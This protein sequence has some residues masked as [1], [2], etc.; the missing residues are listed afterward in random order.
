MRNTI[1][2]IIA[3][4]L[5][6]ACSVFS[7][8]KNEP[9]NSYVLNTLP[10]IHPQKSRHQITVLVTQPTTSDI[11]N[12]TQMVY[13]IGQHQVAYFAK[14][15]WADTP[16][17]M[18]QSLL[19]QTLQNT[20]YFYAE[21]PP[22]LARYHYV[23]N[24]QLLQFEQQFFMHSSDVVISLRVQIIKTNNDKIIAAKQFTVREPAPENT[25]YGGVVAANQA[26]AKLTAQVV[27]FC[28]R[29]L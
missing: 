26:A 27:K 20:K 25:P 22:A 29:M 7:P 9:V 6:S 4:F 2:G 24:T 10:K 19:I 13:T 28:L 14:N 11:N 18:L 8:V 1:M 3:V 21:L 15:R 17:Q 5:L 23:I 16:A 12:T